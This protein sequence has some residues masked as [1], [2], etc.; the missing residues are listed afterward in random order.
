MYIGISFWVA[1]FRSALKLLV[2]PPSEIRESAFIY[3]LTSAVT[4]H[5][6]TRAC[7][8]GDLPTCGCDTSRNGM[9]TVQGWK[10][11]SCS[12]NVSYGLTYAQ[13]FLDARE[14]DMVS[15]NSRNVSKAMVHLHN[16]AVG[17]KVG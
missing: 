16:N 11:G 8:N 7:S 10:W 9:T 14:L 6:I 4:A 15:T 5:Q 17:R 2:L 13:R 1:V 3:A 12:D